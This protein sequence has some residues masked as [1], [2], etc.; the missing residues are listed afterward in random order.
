MYCDKSIDD[1][2]VSEDGKSVIFT[3]SFDEDAKLFSLKDLKNILAKIRIEKTDLDADSLKT[4]KDSDLSKEQSANDIKC[5]TCKDLWKESNW[6]R[7]YNKENPNHGT[8]FRNYDMML[9]TCPLKNE[10]EKPTYTVYSGGAVNK[11]A[12]AFMESL[13]RDAKE[14]EKITVYRDFIIEYNPVKN[15]V[16]PYRMKNSEFWHS[17]LQEVKDN[18][19]YVID[20]KKMK[21][22]DWEKWEE[23]LCT[24]L[25]DLQISSAKKDREI[26]GLKEKINNF[27]TENIEKSAL[28]SENERLKEQLK[29][30]GIYF[31]DGNFYQKNPSVTFKKAGT[32]TSEQQEEINKTTEWRPGGN[33]WIETSPGIWETEMNGMRL[34]TKCNNP[35]KPDKILVDLSKTEIEN[36]LICMKEIQQQNRSIEIYPYLVPKLQPIIDKLEKVIG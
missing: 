12:T 17:S 19:N 25:I 23:D 11:G 14:P 2:K 8:G 6:V 13:V 24:Q 3:M 32:L 15:Q 22:P 35:N 34:K 4:P 1:G 30:K 10:P 31:Y 26:Q 20:E 36:I 28:K 9:S 21:A 5:E 33:R 27:C 16:F 29:L 7:C 18:I